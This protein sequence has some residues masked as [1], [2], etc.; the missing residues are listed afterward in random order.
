MARAQ[1]KSKLAV[2]WASGLL[3]SLAV[4]NLCALL[5]ADSTEVSVWDSALER[6]VRRAGQ[7]HH[8][9]TEG[10]A[11]T[12][13]GRHGVN[14]IADIRELQGPKVIFWGDSHVEGFPLADEE[15]LAQQF[16]RLPQ[17]AA[18]RPTAFA[19]G[20]SGTTIATAFR[21][22]PFYEKVAPPVR[23]HF[24]VITRL[25]Y[26]LPGEESQDPFALRVSS[27]RPSPAQQDV[28][29]LLRTLRMPL[30]YLLYRQAVGLDLRFHPGMWSAEAGDA[31]NRLS[32][33]A[34]WPLLLERL[35]ARTDVPV[36]FVYCPAIPYLDRG[37]PVFDDPHRRLIGEFAEACR[38]HR[39]PFL[40]LHQEFSR[41]Y[42][43]SGRFPRGFANNNPYRGHLNPEGTRLVAEKVAAF[44]ARR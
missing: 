33:P 8:H 44:L 43:A 24:I 10:W 30:P 17:P 35:A 4:A 16:N 2:A 32:P 26:I 1:E 23:Y 12:R 27:K 39:I 3:I 9:R 29:R 31:P 11:D 19:V 21:L 6:S 7:R 41:L 28:I 20:F 22:I 15:K 36:G 40:N 13:I 18:D 37:R 38:R 42:R 25:R 5:F 34:A 14:G